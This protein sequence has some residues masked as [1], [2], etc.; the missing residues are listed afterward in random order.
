[1]SL[2][3]AWHFTVYEEIKLMATLAYRMSSW[4]EHD[5]RERGG[6]RGSGISDCLQMTDEVN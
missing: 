6:G 1:M 3:G 5:E 4:H 2:V